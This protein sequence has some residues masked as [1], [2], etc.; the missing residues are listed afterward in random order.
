MQSTSCEMLGWST[1]WN[2]DCREKYQQPQIRRWHHSNGRKWRGT[3]EPLDEDERREWKSWLKT[4]HSRNYDHGVQYHHLMA[5]G[6]GNKGNSDRLYFLGLQN[7]CWWWLQPWKLKKKRCFLLGR[8]A[9]INL[10]T[11]LKSR[12]IT[13]W[14]K[15]R[16]VT[17][18][19]FPVITYGCESWIIKKTEQ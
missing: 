9:M 11:I 3:K 4:Q 7:H 14:T 12:D 16:I 2:L 1:S 15:V 13:F 5:N 18:M 19:V 6:W 8:K 10:Y 17:A